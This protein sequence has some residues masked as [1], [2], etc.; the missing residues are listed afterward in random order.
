MAKTWPAYSKWQYK[1]NGDEYLQSI[2]G[3]RLV[4]N[5][6]PIDDEWVTDSDFYEIISFATRDTISSN[7]L[8]YSEFLQEMNENDSATKTFFVDSELDSD[9]LKPQ[10]FDS[11]A[12]YK[13]LEFKQGQYFVEVAQFKR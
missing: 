11:I 7:K 5:F 13:G 10:F 4:Q 6:P 3:Q 12:E 9:I 8:T 2:F 1:N